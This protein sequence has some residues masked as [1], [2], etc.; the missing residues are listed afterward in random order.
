VGSSLARA[1]KVKK[2][3][4]ADGLPFGFHGQRGHQPDRLRN[5]LRVDSGFSVEICTFAANGCVCLSNR[6]RSR[7]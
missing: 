2:R 4:Q 7:R 3:P 1:R 5:G 6:G